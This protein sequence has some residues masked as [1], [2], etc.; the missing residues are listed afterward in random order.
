MD[1]S[2][3]LQGNKGAKAVWAEIKAH[4]IP[5]TGS[6]QKHGS[7]N[8]LRGFQET[9]GYEAVQPDGV[10]KGKKNLSE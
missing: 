5:G 9:P 8:S 7:N 3:V 4:S 6:F 1:G 2:N 10:V